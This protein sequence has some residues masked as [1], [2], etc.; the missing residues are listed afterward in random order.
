V[1]PN[2]RLLTEALPLLGSELPIAWKLEE[3]A[4]GQQ[5]KTAEASRASPS[6][7]NR[8]RGMPTITVTFG[9]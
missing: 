4:L 8:P 1:A 9:E 2:E 3:H 7:R 5:L 6:A